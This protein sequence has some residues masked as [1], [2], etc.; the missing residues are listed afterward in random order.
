MIGTVGL[1]YYFEA[2]DTTGSVISL[3]KKQVVLH[4]DENYPAIPNLRFGATVNQYQII[5]VPLILQNTNA[6][7]VFDELGEYN[8]KNW[9]KNGFTLS[10]L[11]AVA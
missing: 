11:L 2:V 7:A 6:E 8:I 3:P 9:L 1:Y 4:Y 10:S 5:S